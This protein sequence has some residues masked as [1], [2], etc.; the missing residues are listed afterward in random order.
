LRN[1]LIILL[2]LILF[3]CKTKTD[4]KEVQFLF[5]PSFLHPTKFKIN[6]ENSTIEQY[7][8][9]D[10]YYVKEW[11][12]S[13]SHK[14]HRKDT[15]IVHYKNT[16]NINKSDLDEFLTELNLSK[17]DSTIEH[18]R[19][20]LDGIG[21]RVSKINTLNDTISLTSISPNRTEEYKMDYKILDAFFNL[22]YK[23]IDDYNGI[24]RIENIQD[25]F[26]YGLA[27]KKM[28]N[29][30]LEYRIWGTISGCK[31]DNPEFV[32]LL[33]SL[34]LNKP[35]IFD[36]RNG[37][38]APC[39]NSLLNEYNKKKI[40]YYGNLELTGVNQEIKILEEQLKVAISNNNNLAIH[41]IKVDIE[42]NIRY[43]KLISEMELPN[44]FKTKSEL[45]K[46]IANK[47]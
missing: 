21:F 27:I 13:T 39:L 9:Q 43:K 30:P 41:N 32:K 23:S 42:N 45:I 11:I 47:M 3:S 44:T 15:L 20:V 22:S 36:L 10:S 37:S 29:D 12:D 31:S 33:N 1:P 28:N 38:I 24:S 4:L 17:L 7:T 8:Y 18:R 16:F 25:Y 5:A 40:Y 14:T 46:T 2:T 19:S 34:P 35:T 6:I 26:N